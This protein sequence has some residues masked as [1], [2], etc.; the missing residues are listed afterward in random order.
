L[1]EIEHRLE[2]AGLRLIAAASPPQ[3]PRA[4]AIMEEPQLLNLLVSRP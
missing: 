3:A 2:Q 1:T 4:N